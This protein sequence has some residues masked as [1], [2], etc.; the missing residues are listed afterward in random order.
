MEISQSSEVSSEQEMGLVRRTA[1]RLSAATGSLADWTGHLAAAVLLL[2]TLSI[3]LGITLRRVGIDNSWTYDLDLFSLI[4]LSFTGAVLTALR[5][6]HVTA[7]I[8]LEKLFGGQTIFFSLLRFAVVATFLVIF[9]IS[10]Y[11]QMET[12]FV[13]NERTLDVVSWSVW[14]A[15]AALPVGGALWLVAEAHKLLTKLVGGKKETE[16]E[17]L[18]KQG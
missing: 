9:T 3:V 17:R 14:I 18:E 13:T 2:L 5:G 12:S 8:S 7:G 6:R 1:R 11:R 4:W 10:G 15:Q 16:G